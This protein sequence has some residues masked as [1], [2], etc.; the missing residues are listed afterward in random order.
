M[1]AELLALIDAPEV[2]AVQATPPAA[3]TIQGRNANVEVG[4]DGAFEVQPVTQSGPHHIFPVEEQSAY[5][6][7]VAQTVL[8][9]VYTDLETGEATVELLAPLDKPEV[10]AVQAT[11][12]APRRLV[13]AFGGSIKAAAA[14]AREQARSQQDAPKAPDRKPRTAQPKLRARTSPAPKAQPISPIVRLGKRKH[15]PR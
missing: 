10:T 13:D 4:A 14:A 3:K 12:P 2:T 15:G 8:A 1:R 9:R 5:P 6:A 7:E 11:P